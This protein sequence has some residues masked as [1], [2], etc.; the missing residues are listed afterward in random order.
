LA[1]REVK[2]LVWTVLLGGV[3]PEGGRRSAAP[4][5]HK[6]TPTTSAWLRLTRKKKGLNLYENFGIL[7]LLEHP[8]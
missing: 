6:K 7:I 4:G 5:T 8:I 1:V 3:S 2:G